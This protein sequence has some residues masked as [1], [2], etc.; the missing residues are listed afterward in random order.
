MS[1]V[2]GAS[3]QQSSAAS[4]TKKQCECNPRQQSN[5]IKVVSFSFISVL[6]LSI[7]RVLDSGRG[8]VEDKHRANYNGLVHSK[9][10]FVGHLNSKVVRSFAQQRLIERCCTS[11]QSKQL[12]SS[13]E[14]RPV[15]SWYTET[16]S[17]QGESENKTETLNPQLHPTL[18]SPW[19]TPFCHP[20]T[21][22][23]TGVWFML[24]CDFRGMS[25]SFLFI[26]APSFIFSSFLDNPRIMHSVE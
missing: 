13:C 24:L 9:I 23:C 22:T 20:I 5:G 10:S 12:H 18:H 25:P 1:P 15:R 19:L 11:A 6:S 16:S 7:R 3:G 26:E 14:G 8:R 2:P 21:P 4:N 17:T